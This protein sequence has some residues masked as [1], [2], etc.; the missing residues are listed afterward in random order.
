MTISYQFGDVDA[1][2]ATIR[3][4]A[5]SLEAEHQAIVRDVLGRGF[6]GRGRVRGL[7]GV[8]NSIGAQLPGDLRAGQCTRP[9]GADRRQQHGRYR[10][11]RRLQ[12]GLRLNDVD[13]SS[14]TSIHTGRPDATAGVI[15]APAIPHFAAEGQIRQAVWQR[16]PA[17]MTQD[18]SIVYGWRTCRVYA[19]RRSRGAEVYLE[20]KLFR[21]WRQRGS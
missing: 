7:S 3:A 5:A 20:R 8:H 2:G 13:C 14:V 18:I 12:L 16:Y 21:P 1:H 6:L 4:E 9:K 11:C 10:W 15:D 19:P 17:T